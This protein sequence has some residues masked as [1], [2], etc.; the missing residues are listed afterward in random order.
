MECQQLRPDEVLDFIEAEGPCV[1]FV[2]LHPELDFNDALQRLCTAA[3][4]FRVGR[5]LLFELIATEAPALW[6]MRHGLHRIDRAQWGDILPG[7]YLF[8]GPQLVD[9][10]FGLANF[11][12]TRFIARSS[13][14]GALASLMRRD[15]S[16]VL[17]SLRLGARESVGRRLHGRFVVSLEDYR[18]SPGP[19]PPPPPPGGAPSGPSFTLGIDEAYRVLGVPPSASDAEVKAAWRR[20]LAQNH[21]DRAVDDR[22]EF[23]RRCRVCTRINEAREL[24]VRHRAHRPR[25]TA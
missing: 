18:A 21:P 4:S 15:R 3:K 9:F 24:I 20:E 11:E 16:Y 13:V 14:L 1:L 25:A 12:D 23:E 2:S 10:D 17:V 8:D 22:D 5:A 19:P 6:L 7:Y